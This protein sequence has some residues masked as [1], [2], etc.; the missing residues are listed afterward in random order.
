MAPPILD[1]ADPAAAA[2][3]GLARADAW[4]E[5]SRWVE[6]FRDLAAGDAEAL[7]ELYDMAGR[8]LY[9]LALW[10]TGSRD[11][12]AEVV[13]ETFVR[14][15]ECGERLGRVRDPRWWLLSVA[16]RLAVDAVRRAARHRS[17]PIEDHADLEA[18]PRDHARALDARRAWAL[19]AR[20]SPR[21]RE[22]VWLHDAAGMSHAEI[23]RC[24]G[25]PAF[26]AASRYRL[27]LAA[28]RRLLGSTT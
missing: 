11:L 22:A 16:H 10:R 23:G 6:L 5:P 1:A 27:A 9:G 4:R 21:Q 3:R 15:A 25:I 2:A 19:V 28:L 14:V 17:E 7:G 8:R 13:Q 24:L 18:E 26:T 12:A 20:L